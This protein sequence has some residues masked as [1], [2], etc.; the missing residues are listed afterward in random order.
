MG[1]EDLKQMLNPSKVSQALLPEM[2][3]VS[4]QTIRFPEAY[5]RLLGIY[6]DGVIDDFIWILSPNSYN[7]NLNFETSLYLIETYQTL[8]KD[9]P[10]DY[11]RPCYP[12]EGSF[13]PWAITDNGDSLSWMVSQDDSISTILIHS[14]D[15]ATEELFH[16]T[17]AEFLVRL[18]KREIS[19]SLLPEQFPTNTSKHSFS[20]ISR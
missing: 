7:R 10:L 3:P 2:I 16:L 4:T 1:I 18:L 11:L 6:Q 9:F 5:R 12:D 13:F 8:K 15:Q 20:P 17:P 14:P 19:S